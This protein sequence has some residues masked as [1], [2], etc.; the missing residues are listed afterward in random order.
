MFFHTDHGP[1]LTEDG[2]DTWVHVSAP[3][4]QGAVSG[5]TMPGGAYDPTPGSRRIVSAVG[6]W[7]SR[8]GQRLCI[9][10]DDGRTWN[11]WQDMVADYRFFA[12]HPQIPEVVYVGTATGGLR[13]EDAGQTWKPIDKSIR[14]MFPANGDFIYAVSRLGPGGF[15][16]ERSKDRGKTWKPLGQDLPSPVNEI[17]VDPKNADRLYAALSGR[18]GGIWIYD[19][20]RWTGRDAANGLEKDFFGEMGFY[21]IAVDPRRPE[22][23][24]AGQRSSHG[25]A[26]GIFRSTDYG[27]TWKNINGNFDPE[28]TVWAITISPHDSTVWL[29]TSHG[30]WKLRF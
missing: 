28:L 19:G 15:R 8:G 25:V 23:I 21:N 7:A 6:G 11:V 29:G 2:G 13:S 3:R 27:Q 18:N 17:D 14:T 1:T 30:N 16:V 24:Y 4:Q 12:W 5:R 9:S 10:N 20:K 22:V 26:H